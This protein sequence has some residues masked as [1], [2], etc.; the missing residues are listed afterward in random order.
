MTSN[1][2]DNTQ[3]LCEI[4]ISERAEKEPTHANDLPGIYT[5]AKMG[6]GNISLRINVARNPTNRELSSLAWHFKNFAEARGH[7]YEVQ[8]GTTPRL[9]RRLCTGDTLCAYIFQ[10]VNIGSQTV[11]D[12]SESYCREPTLLEEYQQ[13]INPGQ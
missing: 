2:A 6:L 1:L 12:I 4:I 13:K 11:V 10:T 8:E 5:S 9:N 7:S 3:R